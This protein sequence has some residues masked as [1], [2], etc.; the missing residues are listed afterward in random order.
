MGDPEPPV[1]TYEDSRAVRP[2]GKRS[3]RSKALV[4]YGPMS[5]YRDIAEKLAGARLPSLLFSD[6]NG[7][8]VDLNTISR[9]ALVLYIQPGRILAGDGSQNVRGDELQHDAYRALRH[10]QALAWFQLH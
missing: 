1:D 10:R 8:V 7:G 2:Q 6:Y 4:G 9:Y 3:I 5:E